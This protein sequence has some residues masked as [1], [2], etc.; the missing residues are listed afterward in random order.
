[1][2]QRQEQDGERERKDQFQPKPFGVGQDAAQGDAGQGRQRE[3]G[4]EA[5]AGAEEEGVG[6]AAGVAFL[7]VRDGD[8]IGLISQDRGQDW[9]AWP[10]RTAAQ[11]AGE[12]EAI[13]DVAQVEDEGRQDDRDE[14]GA[15]VEEGDHRHLGRSG[16][17]EH[18][19]ELGLDRAEA[20]LLGQDPVSQPNGATPSQSGSIVL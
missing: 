8:P 4:V 18:R 16:V 13:E 17:D 6:P 9:P 19:A 7:S 11:L 15:V 2:E 14:G 12:R 3:W 5:D 1:M 20:G 10:H